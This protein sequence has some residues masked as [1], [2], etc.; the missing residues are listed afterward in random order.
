[1][2]EDRLRAVMLT[3]SAAERRPVADCRCASCRAAADGGGG[4]GRSGLLVQGVLQVDGDP[5][6]DS[7]GG[8]EPGSGGP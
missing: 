1:M 5:A 7:S 6:N 8:S 4:R 2:G 3:G